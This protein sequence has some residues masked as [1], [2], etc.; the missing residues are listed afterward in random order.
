MHLLPLR[1][2]TTKEAYKRRTTPTQ[3]LQA[4]HRPLTAIHREARLPQGGSRTDSRRGSATRIDRWRWSGTRDDRSGGCRPLGLVRHGLT[5]MLSQTRCCTQALLGSLASIPVLSFVLPW[6]LWTLHLLLALCAPASV[7]S[8]RGILLCIRDLDLP[9]LTRPLGYL[10]SYDTTPR[11]PTLFLSSSL[12]F[13]HVYIPYHTD[14]A[15]LSHHHASQCYLDVLRVRGAI[16][17]TF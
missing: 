3:E 8:D 5:F 7:Y 12:M 9:C 13:T 14:F 15:S 10:F 17:P 4:I 11:C 6:L 1:L 16:L 2:W